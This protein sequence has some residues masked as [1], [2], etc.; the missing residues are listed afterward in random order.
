MIQSLLKAALL[1]SDLL[2]ET[3]QAM[4]IMT[5]VPRNSEPNISMPLIMPDLIVSRNRTRGVQP[6]PV[7]RAVNN[8]QPGRY[9]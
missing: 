2:A 1:G 4:A 6:P 5:A 3:M 7:T 9:R 8:D